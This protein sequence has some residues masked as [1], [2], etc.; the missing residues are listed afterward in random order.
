M[1]FLKMAVFWVVAPFHVWN[2]PI[3]TAHCP[4]YGSSEDL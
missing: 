3:I 1:F 4:D 2:S